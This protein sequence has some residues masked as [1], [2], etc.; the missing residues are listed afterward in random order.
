MPPRISS[1]PLAF[2]AARSARTSSST[3]VHASGLNGQ[4][5]A[6]QL[7]LVPALQQTRLSVG[8]VAIRRLPVCSS[9]ASDQ[10]GLVVCVISSLFHECG[11]SRSKWRHQSGG[12]R[13]SRASEAEEEGSRSRNESIV[14][15][16]RLAMRR[17]TQHTLPQL[18]CV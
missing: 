6:V 4:G 2:I 8:V 10:I 12:W 9:N 18:V 5:G 13:W 16:R 11:R 1:M 3:S 14:P 15:D 17:A 7:S